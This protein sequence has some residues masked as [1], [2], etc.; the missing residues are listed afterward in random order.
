MNIKLVRE[1]ND[2]RHFAFSAAHLRA[3]IMCGATIPDQSSVHPRE[4]DPYAFREFLRVHCTFPGYSVFEG[5]GYWEGKR[6]ITRV[7]VVYGPNNVAFA[8]EVR[9]I[10]DAYRDTFNQDAVAFGFVPAGFG[11]TD[12]KGV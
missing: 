5:A 8:A 10:A 4:V 12:P 11:L 9:K 6:E 7:I 2:Q 3:E 1:G